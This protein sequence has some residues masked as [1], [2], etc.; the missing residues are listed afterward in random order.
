M[1][2]NSSIALSEIF[3]IYCTSV[4]QNYNRLGA[5]I[6]LLPYPSA[7]CAMVVRFTVPDPMPVEAEKRV[8]TAAYVSARIIAAGIVI[9]FLYW[10]ASVIVT[11]LVAVLLAYFLDPVVAR[12]EDMGLPRGLG[13]SGGSGFHHSSFPDGLD[14]GRAHRSIWRGLAQVP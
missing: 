14:G 8:A 9:A 11:L 12:L 4:S 3:G 5:V 2:P 13:S 1:S 6:R 10:A 7:G